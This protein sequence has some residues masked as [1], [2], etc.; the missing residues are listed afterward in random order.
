MDGI[1]MANSLLQTMDLAYMRAEIQMA[2]PD[3]VSIIRRSITSDQQ[4]GYSEACGD[5][6]QNV[7]ARILISGGGESVSE[8]QQSTRPDGTLT[9]ASSQSVEQTDRIVHA[10]GTYEI[11]F[12]D[13]GKSWD[14]TKRCQI[15]RI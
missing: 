5:A 12:I 6:Y 7:S 13:T 1:R 3:T 9:V 10:S 11:L 14:L 15:R 8:G 2:L 4:G